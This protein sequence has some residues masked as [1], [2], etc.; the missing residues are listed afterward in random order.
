MRPWFNSWVGKIPWRRDRQPTPVFLPGEFLEQRTLAGYS[1]W[2]CNES[3]MIERL[4]ISTAALWDPEWE[5]SGLAQGMDIVSSE[6]GPSV[7]ARVLPAM[8]NSVE[9]GWRTQVKLACQR[10]LGFEPGS[11]PFLAVSSLSSSLHICTSAS[12]VKH[13]SVPAEKANDRPTA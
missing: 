11:C 13:V 1:P 5:A 2:G 10:T 6:S 7:R 4:S 12:S 8:R 9:L 3:D